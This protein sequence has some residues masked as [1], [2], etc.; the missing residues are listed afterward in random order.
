MAA[1]RVTYKKVEDSSWTARR[2]I[3]IQLERTHVGFVHVCPDFRLHPLAS[4]TCRRLQLCGAAAPFFWE[5]PS[6]F[7]DSLRSSNALVLRGS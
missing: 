3:E 7:L 2:S 6:S 5:L 1:V 4:T